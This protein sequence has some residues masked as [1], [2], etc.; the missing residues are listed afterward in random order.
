VSF[1]TPGNFIVRN[2]SF[3]AHFTKDKET[4]TDGKKKIIYEKINCFSIFALILFSA[5]I[6]RTFTNRKRFG[7]EIGCA[8]CVLWSDWIR[9]LWRYIILHN[10]CEFPSQIAHETPLRFAAHFTF[11]RAR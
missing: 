9:S 11:R 5:H 2:Q 10:A 3:W 4:V 8:V 7:C 6:E 1:V